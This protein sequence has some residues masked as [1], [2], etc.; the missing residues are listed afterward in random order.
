[1]TFMP[2]LVAMG[3]MPFSSAVARPFRPKHLGMLG[4][5]MSASS[6]PTEHSRRRRVVASMDVTRDLPTP[7][8][9]LT[10]PMTFF[11]L[12]SAFWGSMRLS[13]FCLE[14]QSAPQEEQSWVQFSMFS[15]MVCDSPYFR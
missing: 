5:V 2:V 1:M 3:Y 10:T 8:L 14:G 12:L 9:P 4:P 6:M 11:T 15:L 13:G 7:P